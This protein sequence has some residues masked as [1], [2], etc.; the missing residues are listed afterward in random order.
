MRRAILI[1]LTLLGC[2]SASGNAGF[3]TEEPDA[4]Q[5]VP[6]A[7]MFDASPLPEANT[8]PVVDAELE[9]AP[10]D[11]N[12]CS[13]GYVTV[14]SSPPSCGYWWGWRGC[15]VAP[16]QPAEDPCT[17]CSV[18]AYSGCQGTYLRCPSVCSTQPRDGGGCYQQGAAGLE[19]DWCC[20]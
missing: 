16:T 8:P 7:A 9:P 12:P 15:C 18:G 19:I 17:A 2:S 14:A 10:V 3:V 6:G 1:A 4:Q 20:Q 13:P 5:G 11:A